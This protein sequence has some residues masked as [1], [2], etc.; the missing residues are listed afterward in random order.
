MR[1]H[2][3]LLLALTFCALAA[4]TAGD[5]PCE[6]PDRLC[7]TGEWIF[8]NGPDTN[9]PIQ[10]PFSNPPRNGLTAYQKLFDLPAET[11]D[12]LAL[13][14]FDGLVGESSVLLNGLP[15]GEHNSFTPFWFDVSDV[16]NSAA[17]NDLIVL[18]DDAYDVTTTPYADV[19]WINY[20]GIHRNVYLRCAEKALLTGA[21]IQYD[22]APDFSSV[23]GEITVRAAALPGTQI[24]FAA[25]FLEGEP[26]NYVIVGGA[27]GSGQLT[28][29][30]ERAVSDV[31]TFSL[32]N[33]RL[34][35]PETPER[36][37]VY[38]VGFVQGASSAQTLFQTGFRDIRVEGNRI[39]LNGEPL[40]LRGISRHDIYYETGFLGTPEQAYADMSAIKA[41]GANWVRLIHYP[42]PPYV[43]DAADELGLL[44]SEELPGWAA[45]N[46]PL[47]QDKLLTMGEEMVRRDM[48]HP[49]V[50]LWISG[51]ARAHPTAY[52]AA[53]Q[54][55]FKSL[56][57]NRLATY[58]I[59]N[60]QYDPNTIAVDVQLY[61]DADLDLYMKITWWFYYVEYLQDAWANFPKDIPIVIAEFGR[62]GNDREP[63]VVEDDE[64]FWWG[65][66]QQ[67]DA[68]AEMC[69]AWRPHLPMYDAEEFISGMCLFNWQDTDWPDVVRFL[70]N[71]IPQLCWGL[72]YD[73]RAPKRALDTITQFYS[74]LPD[75]FVG[76]PTPD[77]AAVE[78]A[79]HNPAN[80][81]SP[82]NTINRDSGPSLSAD[83]NVLF[84]ASDGP[85]FVG[86]PKI[87]FS[88]R[89]ADGWSAPQLF[90]I[91]QE[92]D[93]FAF[94]R[95]PCIAY[96]MQTLYFTR[97]VVSG[98][99]VAQTRIW[100]TTWDGA[101]W[102]EPVDLGDLVNYPDSA[103]ITSD[104][105]VLGDNRTLFFSSDR[106]GGF[107]RTDLW[108]SLDVDGEWT[109]PSNLGPTVNT[110]YGESEPTLTAD[111]RTLYFTSDRPGGLGS[112]D[113]W[114]THFVAGQW[115]EP[116]NL[117]PELNSTGGDREAE[118]S[119]DG[120]FLLFTGIR[121][122]GL[123]LSDL[124]TA[125]ALCALVDADGDG[126][127][128][129]FESSQLMECLSGPE[130]TPLSACEL[131]DVDRDGDV[132]L[133][134]FSR[135]Q[136]CYAP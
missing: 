114:V 116:R 78:R 87:Y 7:L 58:V 102:T 97:A 127:V 126:A 11:C 125:E 74:T 37:S 77:D 124:W 115:T 35:S 40:F 60:D 49:S 2:R 110:E 41:A 107:G 48:H 63:I 20:S 32:A 55:M 36:Y 21:E 6:R 76:L 119:K 128:S 43:L 96:D 84:F 67:A 31:L 72:V 12:G 108:V 93:E 105:A 13:L 27:G 106:P 45:F 121:S 42:H 81:G 85:E 109:L 113:I 82:I 10:V 46:D 98:I 117:G 23:S 88:E 95:A 112:S 59:D 54:Q 73:D 91:P 103:R 129:G 120:R 83:G 14:H 135:L 29:G 75:E 99:Y 4:H 90:N 53:A 89:V 5:E 133:L 39:L 18:I 50:F 64:E 104:P 28:V 94:R 130:A 79:Y 68:L 69:E 92:T 17:T 86:R 24:T 9:I 16:L 62:E 111:G 65:E 47:V 80:L 30:P 61:H 25:Y 1:I 34:W 33:P 44:V 15:L 118:V 132:D 66:D 100:K 38:V 123:G 8:W 136:R 22:L 56:D 134:D 26:G 122:G 19:P 3:I 71:H 70:P 101:H 131:S 57:R 51:V 52:A